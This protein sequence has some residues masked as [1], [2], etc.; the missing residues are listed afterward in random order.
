MYIFYIII[1]LYNIYNKHTLILSFLCRS[2]TLTHGY[3]LLQTPL[4]KNL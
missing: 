1:H 3:T 2:D 4:K